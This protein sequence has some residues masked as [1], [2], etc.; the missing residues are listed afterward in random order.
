MPSTLWIGP[1]ASGKTHLCVEQVRE[2]SRANLLSTVWALL[3]DRHQARGFRRRLTSSGGALGVRVGT[4]GDLYD[5]VL[6]Q[7]DALLPLAPEPVLHR[8]IQTVLEQ[9]AD[10]GRLSHYGAIKRRP[11]LT[12][13]LNDLFAEWKRSRVTPERL[14]EVV[15]DAGPRLEELATAYDRYQTTL[16]RS[17]WADDEGRGWLAIEELNRN[18]RLGQGWHIVVDGFDSYTATQRD[19]LKI[20]SARGASLTLTL[21]GDT[22]MSRSAYRRFHTTLQRLVEDGLSLTTRHLRARS[23]RPLVLRRLADALFQAPEPTG[24]VGQGAPIITDKDSAVTLI[25]AQ[26]GAIEAREAIRWLKARHLRDGVALADCI[27]IARDLPPYEPYLREAAREFGVPLAI[28]AGAPL[29]DNP[30]VAALLDALT[31]PTSGWGNRSLSSVVRSPYLRLDAFGLAPRDAL[32]LEA[33]ARAGQVVE[34]LDQ[35]REA[36]SNLAAVEGADAESAELADDDSRPPTAPRGVAA[37]RLADSFFRLAARLTPEAAQSRRGFV[38]W[39]EDLIELLQLEAAFADNPETTDRDKSA[40][41]AVREIFAALILSDDVLAARQ[42]LTY[43]EFVNEVRG[44]VEASRYQVEQP[45]WR[46]AVVAMD[47]RLARGVPYMAVAVL[48][49]SESQF[50][51]PL[52]EDPFLSDDERRG[53]QERGLPLEPR[54]RSD[55]QSLFYEAVTRADRHLLLTRSYLAPDGE[56]WQ[57]SPY[58]QAVRALVA[59]Q[60]IRVRAGDPLALAEAASDVEALEAALAA[61]LAPDHAVLAEWAEVTLRAR[62]ILQERL[63][64]DSLGPFDGDLSDSAQPL[65]DRFGTKHVWSASRLEAYGACG[66]QFFVGSGLG[67]QPRDPVRVGLDAAQL[68]TLVHNILEN[69]YQAADPDDVEA[70]V[71]ALP[72]V[73]EPIFA[74]AP[75]QLGFRPTSLWARLQAEVLDWIVETLREIATLSAGYRPI[76]FEQRFST[77]ILDTPRGPVRIRGVID[78]IDRNA[79]GELRVIDY[80]TGGSHLD[81]KALERGIRLQLPLYAAA[82]EHSLN[83]GTPVDGLY[84]SVRGAKPGRLTLADFSYTDERGR[85]HAGPAAAIELA[86]AHIGRTVAGVRA[87]I[88]PARAPDGG[89]PDYCPAAAFCW[90]YQPSR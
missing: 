72:A 24:T 48:G 65:S 83:L 56:F 73:A 10:E 70:L 21:T 75:R 71:A 15:A 82:A 17:G 50:P 37:E 42:A 77:L 22:D 8:L 34:G 87:G 67:L 78:R 52:T 89:C 28:S 16:I 36:F 45:E 57:P 80:K 3:P 35:W 32:R 66:F 55:Q 46:E 9:L 33:V 11:G 44:A 6:A 30:A 84:W 43:A 88:F 41:S 1:A 79:A 39:V 29:I 60:P 27:V 85:T 14:I 53:L 13:A 62:G 31:L 20:L 74:A 19:A 69:I 25:E 64:T 38:V 90:H 86:A 54:L 51:A 76:A 59:T 61:G 18:D 49:L 12:L 47:L 7:A 58:W 5:E 68:G 4:F 26:T 23:A 2:A 81:P 40:L 63:A